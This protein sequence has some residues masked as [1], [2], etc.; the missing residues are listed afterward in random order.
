MAVAKCSPSSACTADSVVGFVQLSAR[1]RAIA[2]GV[3]TFTGN[4]TTIFFGGFESELSEDNFV[5]GAV[6]VAVGW[7]AA[8][9][10]AIFDDMRLMSERLTADQVASCERIEKMRFVVAS[11]SMER[12]R[13]MAASR[14]SAA[15]AIAI[16]PRLRVRR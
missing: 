13:A 15:G 14:H 11:G 8:A 6:G 12:A 9:A 1:K 5:A 3:R 16:N 7:D 4:S 2:L 10:F